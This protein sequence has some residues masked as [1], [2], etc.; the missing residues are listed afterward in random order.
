MF[1]VNDSSDLWFSSKT[2]FV[3]IFFCRKLKF[4]QGFLLK[5]QIENNSR[6]FPDNDPQEIS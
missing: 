5:A 2:S 3:F 4:F 6:G 1:M